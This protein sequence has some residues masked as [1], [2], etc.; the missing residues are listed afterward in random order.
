[1]TEIRSQ[2]S[3]I[4]KLDGQRLTKKIILLALCSLLLAPCSSV[5]AQQPK[6]MPL[7][8]YIS[9]GDAASSSARAEGIRPGLRE[10]GYIDGQTIAI[11]YRYEEGKNDRLP[12][13]AAELV[14]L[15]VDIIVVQG[16]IPAVR[17]TKNATKTIPIVMVG[18]GSDPVERGVVESI[19][20][21]GGNVTGITNL[22]RELGGKRLELFQDAS[23]SHPYSGSPRN[24]HSG[25]CTRAERGPGRSA[26]ARVD[27]SVLGGTSCGRS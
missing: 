8:G 18:T 4:G 19:A 20:R 27:Y 13:L 15:K 9:S 16:G 23:Q 25:H 21:P 1:M 6:K 7:I 17:A 14:R 22:T 26:H 24:G 12:E 5:D 2:M 3:E 10:L 11:E